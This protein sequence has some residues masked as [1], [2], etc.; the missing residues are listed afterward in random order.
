LDSRTI[1]N[2]PCFGWLPLRSIVSDGS[3]AGEGVGDGVGLGVGDGE[4]EGVG[5]GE[6][7]GDGEALGVRVVALPLPQAI[8]RSSRAKVAAKRNDRIAIN[9]NDSGG[10][11][12]LRCNLR[13]LSGCAGGL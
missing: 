4:G 9:G 11:S 12:V 7:V 2:P 13:I 10:L 6:S 5:F 1:R 8:T 3:G